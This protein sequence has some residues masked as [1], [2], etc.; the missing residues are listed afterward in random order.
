MNQDKEYRPTYLTNDCIYRLTFQDGKSITG[1]L[2]AVDKYHLMVD[3]NVPDSQD[4]QRLLVYKHAL[5][6]IAMGVVK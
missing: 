1:K 5:K 4:V 2:F 3:V 6:Y